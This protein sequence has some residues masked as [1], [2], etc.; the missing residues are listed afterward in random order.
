MIPEFA[1]AL[2][3]DSCKEYSG[4]RLRK[5]P[6]IA[7]AY[8]TTGEAVDLSVFIAALA[9]TVRDQEIDAKNFMIDM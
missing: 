7:H 1:L 9:A 4:R 6:L 5:L 8:H 3:A 2:V